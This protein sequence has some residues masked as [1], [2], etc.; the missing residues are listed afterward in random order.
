[1]AKLL[2]DWLNNQVVLSRQVANI[3]EDFRDGYLLGELLYKHNQVEDFSLFMNK[4]S[5]AAR[6]NNF[7]LLE[8]TMR[9]I[10]INFN[11]K[12]AFDIINAK[13]G[14]CYIV[15]RA[16]AAWYA[17]VIFCLCVRHYEDTHV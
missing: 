6:I 15:W 9:A 8:P 3:D 10:G 12:I 7:T 4:R 5:S 2:L 14:M 16:V 13:P 1:M 11:S 17:N